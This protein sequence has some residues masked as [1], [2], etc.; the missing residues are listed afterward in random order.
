[1]V[2]AALFFFVLA[3]IALVFGATNFA[4]VSM[5]MG[6]LLLAVFLALAVISFLVSLITG[7]R[8]PLP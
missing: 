5:D 4:G 8:P 7:R 1:M 6:R 3:L 2:R